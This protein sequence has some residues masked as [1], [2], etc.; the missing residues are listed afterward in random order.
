M[1]LDKKTAIQ[2]ARE[3]LGK[4]IF[5]PDNLLHASRELRL[6][7]AYYSCWVFDGTLEVSWSCEVAEGSGNNRH[8]VPRN[9]VYTQFFGEVLVSG[10][11][12][13]S[14]RDLASVEPYNLVEVEQFKPEYLAGWPTILYDR[15]LSDAS[16]VARQKVMKQIRSQIQDR[17]EIGSDKRRVRTSGGKWSGMTFKHILLPLWVGRYRFRNKEFHVLVNGQTGEVGGEKPRD[18]VKYVFATLTAVMFLFLLV[19][20]YWVF[21][22]GELP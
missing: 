15:S 11:K 21:T 19:V 5:V 7:P 4:G 8:W 13:L 12:S 9:G 14:A 22:G 1:K 20:L 10:V 18:A 16:L 6:R 2:N 3:W 17:I